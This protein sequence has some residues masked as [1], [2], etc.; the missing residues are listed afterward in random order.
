MGGGQKAARLPGI[1][2]FQITL[3]K[4]SYWEAETPSNKLAANTI[5]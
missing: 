5:P 1:N 4:I 3:K 2:L